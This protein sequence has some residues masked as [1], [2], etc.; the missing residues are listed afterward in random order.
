MKEKIQIDPAPR[1]GRARPSEKSLACSK[2][3]DFARQT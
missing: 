3:A 2:S 1:D